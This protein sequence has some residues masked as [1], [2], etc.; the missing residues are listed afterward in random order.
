MRLNK[1]RRTHGAPKTTL[2]VGAA[3]VAA[4]AT[5]FALSACAPANN[6]AADPNADPVFMLASGADNPLE[7]G[8]LAFVRDEVAPDYGIVIETRELQDSRILNESLAAGELVEIPYE[9]KPSALIFTASFA[10]TPASFLLKR[11]AV[12]L[13]L[14]AGIIAVTLGLFRHV[15]GG[16][17]PDEDQGYVLTQTFL[18]DGASLINCGRGELMVN[19]DVLEALDSG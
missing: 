2:I 1:Y 18:P 9:W 8:V 15:P 14:F 10:H 5:V 13:L 19:Q 7:G 3:V 17:V 11:S 16:L 12:G 4:A 6:E